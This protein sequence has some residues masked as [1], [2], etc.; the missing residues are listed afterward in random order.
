MK[1]LI[2]III[3]ACVTIDGY[4]QSFYNYKRGR[5]FIVSAGTGS[6]TYFGELKDGGDYFDPRPNLNIGL[7]YFVS[8]RISVRLE[9]AWF[10]L[11]GNDEGQTESGK[12]KRNLSFLSNNFEISTV[13]TL[14]LFEN[15][16]R[17]YQRPSFNAYVFAGVG[18]LYFNPVGQIDGE[19]IALQPI[20][21]EGVDYNRSTFVLPYGLGLRYKINPFFNL[22]LEGG[23][24]QTFTDYL[25]DVSTVYIDNSS[26]TDPVHAR[27]ADRSPEIGLPL[28]EAG[29]QRGNPET[30]DS[31][32][33]LNVKLEFYL[34]ST[35]FSSSK[36]RN[37]GLQKKKKKRSRR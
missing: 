1:L 8:P 34:P 4:A 36:L 28:N 13:A 25:D 6:S 10:Q 20:K 22:V 35:F 24:R 31:Y 33:I 21:T 18:Y 3:I 30:N 2:S 37:R 14:Q 15:G 11:E 7:Q 32:F 12:F 19:N 29:V 23:F 5:D 9:T 17:Y 16:S 27:L 26:F